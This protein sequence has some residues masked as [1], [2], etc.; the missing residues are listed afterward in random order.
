MM[1]PVSLLCRKMTDG[2]SARLVKRTCIMFVDNCVCCDVDLDTHGK[3]IG[4]LGLS[5]FL[6]FIGKS[7]EV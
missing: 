2:W 1:D 7:I 3:R 6:F 5:Y 4:S